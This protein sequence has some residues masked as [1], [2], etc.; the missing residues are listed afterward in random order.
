[1]KTLAIEGVSFKGPLLAL[2]G[3]ATLSLAGLLT[4]GKRKWPNVGLTA[5]FDPLR[6]TGYLAA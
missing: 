1:M 3:S 6:T 4:G 2:L 5:E